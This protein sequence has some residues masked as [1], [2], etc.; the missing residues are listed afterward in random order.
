[1]QVVGPVL[2]RP[3]KTLDTELSAFLDSGMRQGLKAV[4]VSMGTLGALF[5]TELLS[6][7]KGLS[8]LPNP[9][10]WKLPDADLPGETCHLLPESHGDFGRF[11]QISFKASQ[12]CLRAGTIFS[13]RPFH[14]FHP[15]PHVSISSADSISSARF[16][17]AS[18]HST[19]SAGISSLKHFTSAMLSI[20]SISAIP[21]RHISI[22]D[23]HLIHLICL[24]AISKWR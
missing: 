4:Y 10:L 8:A 16:H 13:S 2:A 19:P 17:L 24:A 3:A 14:L 18:C 11:Q 23:G 5:T 12:T 7:A 21:S 9:V 22:L 6:M 1:M 20:S 15:T